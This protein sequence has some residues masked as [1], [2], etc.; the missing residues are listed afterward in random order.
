MNDEQNN[1]GYAIRWQTGY[2]AGKKLWTPWHWTRD[3]GARAICGR[4]ATGSWPG[5][6]QHEETVDCKLCKEKLES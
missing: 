5:V 2:R 6:N 3:D 1:G 4:K